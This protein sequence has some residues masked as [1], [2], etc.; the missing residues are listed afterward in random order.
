MSWIVIIF[1]YSSQRIPIVRLRVH[2]QWTLFWEDKS[3]PK[4]VV[5][6]VVRTVAADGDEAVQQL[7][8]AAKHVTLNLIQGWR[9]DAEWSSTWWHTHCAWDVTRRSLCG[10]L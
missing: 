1:S 7:T 5:N 3:S 10:L 4:I 9:R 6:M 2:H 8:N